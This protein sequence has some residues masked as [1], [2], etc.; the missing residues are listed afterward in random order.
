LVALA[1]GWL[2]WQEGMAVDARGP[3]ALEVARQLEAEW[4][5][6]LREV[7]ETG[8]DLNVES[9]FTSAIADILKKRQEAGKTW[10]YWLFPWNDLADMR[11]SLNKEASQPVGHQTG[12]INASK[13]FLCKSGQLGDKTD[14]T[15]CVPGSP[16]HVCECY[17]METKEVEPGY[18]PRVGW[19]SCVVTRALYN[20]DPAVSLA[21]RGN[22]NASLPAEMKRGFVKF[23]KDDAKFFRPGDDEWAKQFARGA[24]KVRTICSVRGAGLGLRVY[25]RLTGRAQTRRGRR[26]AC[27]SWI[28][29]YLIATGLICLCAQA[30]TTAPDTEVT[31]EDGPQEEPPPTRKAVRKNQF[32]QIEPYPEFAIISSHNAA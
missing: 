4:L 8:V 15:H 7:R 10:P 28:C 2:K 24:S 31:E 17:T 22:K 3:E 16:H 23:V 11:E 21:R 25:L 13:M 18:H 26:F 6:W 29:G 9:K 1:S 12:R 19:A 14:F 27:R 5:D 32:S 30:R 20:L